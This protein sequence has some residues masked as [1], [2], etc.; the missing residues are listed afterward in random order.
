[1]SA[2]YVCLKNT[3]HSSSG[4]LLIPENITKYHKTCFQNPW[5]LQIYSD[6][7]KTLRWAISGPV[8]PLVIPPYRASQ[9]KQN[10]YS[11]WGSLYVI[12]FK[13]TMSAQFVS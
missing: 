7:G 1:M 5:T 13:F 12:L 9:Y 4:C 10:R 11:K 6:C 3:A 8:G 2:K